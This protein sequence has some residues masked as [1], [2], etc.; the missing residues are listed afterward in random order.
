MTWIK[1]RLATL[2]L[3]IRLCGFA[4]VM[5]V[6]FVLTVIAFAGT[7]VGLFPVLSPVI[8][9]CRQL[10]QSF[11]SGLRGPDG[12]PIPSPYR[13]EPPTRNDNGLSKLGWL[14]SDPATWMD[15]LWMLLNPLISVLA[16]LLPAVVSLY[17]LVVGG[18][19]WLV[20]P[21]FGPV[22]GSW[23]LFDPTA[24]LG[25]LAWL[26]LPGGLLVAAVLLGT[27]YANPDAPLIVSQTMLAPTPG[28]DLTKRVDELTETRAQAITAQEAELRR[29]ERDLHDGAQVSMVSVGI[30]LRTVERLLETDADLDTIRGL[31]VEARETSA[32]ALRDLRGLVRGIHPPVL[33]ERGLP[34]ALH[35]VALQAPLAVDLDI[36]LAEP[37]EPPI[38]A[39]LY[40]AICELLTNA[41]KHAEAEHASVRLRSTPERIIVT[42]G[43]DGR[44]GADPDRGSGLRGIS[45]RLAS[46]DGTLAISSPAGGPTTATME[47]R[48]AHRH[49]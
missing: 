33:A 36:D 13:P 23:H 15:L 6:P 41:V 20:Q 43:D 22:F 4:L 17:A 3:S 14:V 31:V 28:T 47:I 42:V 9:G 2:W 37:L 11:R 5:L 34:D 25:H 40:F 19:S 10:V 1:T 38:E 16:G 7:L 48:V 35:A 8:L 45:R 39:A 26:G 46:F 27:A 24:P 12:Q 18:F 30:T 44:G 29:I 32:T 21:S 49:R